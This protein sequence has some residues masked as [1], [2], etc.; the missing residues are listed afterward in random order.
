M[1]LFPVRIL[2]QMT[3]VYHLL[4]YL[5]HVIF[6]RQSTT[7]E[8]SMHMNSTI[9]RRCVLPVEII[10]YIIDEAVA[11]AAHSSPIPLNH[12]SFQPLVTPKSSFE[13]IRGLSSTNHWIR[14]RVLAR[15]FRIMVV[16][17]ARDWDIVMKMQISIHVMELRVF[18]QALA[19]PVATDV[20]M[21]FPNLH[22]ALIDAHNDF[23]LHTQTPSDGSQSIGHYRLVAPQ[24]PSTLRR[25]WITNAHGPDVRLIQNA[26]VQCPQLEDLWIERCTL[27]SPRLLPD[28]ETGVQPVHMDDREDLGCHFWNSFPNDHDAYFASIGVADYAHSLAAE[29]RPLKHLK[30]LHMGLYLTPTEALAAHRIHHSNMNIHGPLWEPDCQSC[31]EEFGSDTREAEE[32]AATVLGYEVPSLEEM[33]WSSFHSINKAGRSIFEII[34]QSNG[35]VICRRQADKGVDRE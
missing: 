16:R 11:P 33:S 2:H 21:R 30:R 29:L 13:T 6:R 26:C 17:D 25:L 31:F 32:S 22:T 19:E 28:L 14:A 1:G 7:P 27:F 24:L 9:P 18:S 15:W 10:V 23:V 34:R 8:P 35:E 20:F 3:T 5:W 12:T 4:H